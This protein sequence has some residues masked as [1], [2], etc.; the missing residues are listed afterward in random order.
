MPKS[1]WMLAAYRA[2]AAAA[3]LARCRGC[4][5]RRAAAI[6]ER[7]SSV[8]RSG[9]NAETGRPGG[10]QA[11]IVDRLTLTRRTRIPPRTAR[12]LA[13]RPGRRGCAS[14]C[15][16][17]GSAAAG[18]ARRVA[19]L[20]GAPSPVARAVP[21]S[22]NGVLFP[23]V[24][25]RLQHRLVTVRAT[26]RRRGLPP[27]YSSSGESRESVTERFGRG[28]GSADPAGGAPYPCRRRGSTSPVWRPAPETAMLNGRRG[29]LH[30]V[31]ILVNS[32]ASGQRRT[33]PR[34]CSFSAHRRPLLPAPDGSRAGVT[35]HGTRVLACRVVG[36][37]GTDLPTPD[38]WREDDGTYMRPAWQSWSA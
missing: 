33:P 15:P 34:P 2:R 30:G 23:V 7:W 4:E 9:R 19:Y 35:V 38:K 32:Q 37:Q 10:R 31:D 8:P 16:W 29:D 13:A 6:A 22:G 28:C 27:P 12:G 20:R 36:Q 21:E 11:S 18:C 24:S 3:D 5:G 26:G 17:S 14:P 25:R 1:P